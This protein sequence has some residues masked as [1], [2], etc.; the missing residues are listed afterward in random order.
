MIS[1]PPCTLFCSRL[2]RSSLRCLR[3]ADSFLRYKRFIFTSRMKLS[4]PV[5]TTTL[6][7]KPV[8]TRIC[9]PDVE[10]LLGQPNLSREFGA[11]RLDRML[12]DN[13]MCMRAWMNYFSAKLRR[14]IS[15]REQARVHGR[16]AH[17]ERE[18]PTSF[19]VYFLPPSLKL[20]E[21]RTCAQWCM[22]KDV[23]RQRGINAYASAVTDNTWDRALWRTLSLFAKTVLPFCFGC[24]KC[25]R[26]KPLLFTFVFFNGSLD[27]HRSC[28]FWSRPFGAAR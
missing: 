9:L 26:H 5:I 4:N 14:Q 8:N 27:K 7:H 28:S 12:R 10:F 19:F 20:L 11:T 23:V 18:T 3:K 1:P 25:M 17:G 2:R 21:S 13:K 22:V 15:E 6:Y 24:T 16:S